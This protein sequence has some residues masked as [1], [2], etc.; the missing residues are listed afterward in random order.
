[1]ADRGGD[2][3]GPVEPIGAGIS[4]VDHRQFARLAQIDHRQ[5]ETRAFKEWSEARPSGDQQQQR[6]PDCRQ[7]SL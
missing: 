3:I 7:Y 1:M 4:R 5:L 6:G 2:H